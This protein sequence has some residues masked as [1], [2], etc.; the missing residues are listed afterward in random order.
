M[1]ALPRVLAARDR[2]PFVSREAEL[3]AL[4]SVWRRAAS[5]DRRVALIGG[6]PA[7]GKSRLAARFA[8]R[9]H[10]EG[11]TVLHGHCPE[12]SGAPFPPFV[13]ALREYASSLPPGAARQW[14]AELG[15]MIPSLAAELGEPPPAAEDPAAARFR[16]FEAFRAALDA[17]GDAHRILRSIH[18][19]PRDGMWLGSMAVAAQACAESGD[20]AVAPPLLAAL[21]PFASCWACFAWAATWGPVALWLGE[22]GMLVGRV[23]DAAAWLASIDASGAP[24]WALRVRYARARLG[25]EPDRVELGAVEREARALGLRVLAAA[26]AGARATTAV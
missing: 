15:R 2:L 22:L 24:A 9:V 23:S 11:A 19:I 10:E 7:I 14:P 25:A 1:R 3:A 18:T 20:A 4:D 13:E 26:A 16:R 8:A 17:I 21:E 5:G 12:S 6:D